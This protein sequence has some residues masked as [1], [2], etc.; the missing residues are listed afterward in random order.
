MPSV[1]AYRAGAFLARTAPS[2]LGR[3]A[4]RAAGLSAALA[5]KD[6][7]LLVARNIE[8]ALG[9]TMG[10]VESR[11]RVAAA[12]EW[13]ARYYI[14]SFELPG[15]DKETID[16]GFGYEGV[17]EIHA[18]VDSGIG[19]ILVMPHL[20]TWEWAGWWLSLVPGFDVTVV[21]EPID[22]PEVF[23]WFV[24]LRRSIGMNVV[25]LGPDALSE[26]TRAIK[27]ADV[28]CLLSD[29]DI[30]GGGIPVDFF[31]ER[32]RLPAGPAML[33]L[34]TGAPLIPAAVFWRD[35]YRHG[36]ARPPLDTTRRGKFREDVARLVQ[37]YADEFEH[38]IRL[39]PEQ[40]HLMSPNWPSDYEALGQPVPDSLRD[41]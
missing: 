21:V 19:P 17:G 35:G 26:V 40:W 20:G 24:E 18:A 36:L 4:A 2:P 22:P 9:R 14:E 11:R 25:P 29:R 13:Y 15:L 31:G 1:S 5:A 34:R 37:A 28:V 8:R 33:S 32:T 3:L 10:T 39:A 6:K 41:L 27:R 7:R 38:L 23:E 16:A 12:F 30:G